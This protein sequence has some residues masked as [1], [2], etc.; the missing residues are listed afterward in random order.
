MQ[1]QV[2]D[3][4]LIL[5]LLGRKGG[6]MLGSAK[7]NYPDPKYWANVLNMLIMVLVLMKVVSQDDI[8]EG[9]NFFKAIIEEL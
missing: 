3:R 9:V 8:N 4:L 6:L 5:S 1:L 7:E 2:L